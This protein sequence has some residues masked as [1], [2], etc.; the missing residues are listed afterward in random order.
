M[1][2]ASGQFEIHFSVLIVM[3]YT[4]P[5]RSSRFIDIDHPDL[6]GRCSINDD[7]TS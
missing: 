5:K 4:I 3:N 2:F 6:P 1:F 7:S